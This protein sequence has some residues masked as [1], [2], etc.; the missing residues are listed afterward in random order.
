MSSFSEGVLILKWHAIEEVSK[1]P[2]PIGVVSC[3]A[4]V[5]ASGDTK[6]VSPVPSKA[7]AA[8]LMSAST[9]CLDG[10]KVRIELII[11]P[12]YC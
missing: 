5:I 10:V 2:P 12:T 3:A 11:V 6:L 4:I 7:A 1:T 9:K 8:A